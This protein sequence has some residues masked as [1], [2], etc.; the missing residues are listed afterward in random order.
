MVFI[1]SLANVN[2]LRESVQAHTTYHTLEI[3]NPPPL[4]RFELR[5]NTS[6][7]CT[8]VGMVERMEMACVCRVLLC[9]FGCLGM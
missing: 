4:C 9:L 5:L 6:R 2:L 8:D 1:V 3:Q 7:L